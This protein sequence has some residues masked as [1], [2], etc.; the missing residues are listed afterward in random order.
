ML[1]VLQV[2]LAAAAVVVSTLLVWH[3]DLRDAAGFPT[4]P[5]AAFFS[6]AVALAV[7]A[8]G[9]RSTLRPAALWAAAIGVGQ[10]ASLQLVHA[11]PSV[12]YQHYRLASGG[13]E[14]FDAFCWAFL[15]GQALWVA[16]A[17]WPRRAQLRRF[18]ALRLG[19]RGVA[20]VALV[21]V[22]TAAFPSRELGDYA[23]E[24][25]L[26]TAVRVTLLGS[27]VALFVSLPEASRRAL[28]EWTS[29][30]IA[31]P[32]PA[33]RWP[34]L[35]LW[36]AV[37]ATVASAALALFSY[38]R[39]PHVPDEV[40]YLLHAR[41]FAEGALG[42]PVP[43]VP[44]AFDVYLWPCTELRC[45]SPVPPG[46]PAMLSLGWLLG[47]A[48]LV[49]PLLAGAGILATHRLLRRLY[50][51]QT[52]RLTVLLLATSP[53]YLTVSMSWMT[54]AF[55]LVCALVAASCVAR[56]A[57]R[58]NTHWLAA[59]LGG[60]AIGL[61]SLTRPL[62]GVIVAGVL[63]VAALAARLR[64][65]QLALLG[66][67][68]A[69]VGGL[70]FPYNAAITGD[71]LRFP[72]MA[73]ADQALGVGVNSLGFGP[74]KGTH[75][76]GLDP[77]PG[78]GLGDVI[79]NSLLNGVAIDGEL[80]GWAIGSTLPIAIL[81]GLGRLR[82]NDFWLLFW[83]GA[84]VFA[85]AF[86]WYSG[87]PDFAARYWY[88][89]IVPLA[90]LGARGVLE[91]GAGDGEA[92]RR[93]LLVAGALLL[94]LS[95]VVNVVPW[96]AIDKYH[97]YRGMQPGVREILA[98]LDTPEVLLLVAGEQHPDYASALVYTGL[99]PRGDEPIVAWNRSPE[100]AE[101]LRAAFPERRVVFV[102]GPSVTGAGYRVVNPGSGVNG[103]QT[104]RRAGEK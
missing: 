46:W 66:G 88:L 32:S 63:G 84:I 27:V 26:A 48:W 80:F 5:A 96:R 11:G 95:A 38:E 76:G 62:E 15:S 43:P 25:A 44:E 99:D 30:L 91:L 75:W 90:A 3:P 79:V 9:L 12:H 13:F 36:C 100:V 31:G 102:D 97:H 10:A 77:F 1:V 14:P 6:L 74:D 50:D 55:S 4:T 78:H 51:E 59:A 2:A 39:H 65:I 83:V 7:A 98:E 37:F 58:K 85:H 57:A 42:A 103:V 68:T 47:I 24:V 18:V 69:V 40:A 23:R 101:A 19:L 28:S 56:M 35:V 82:R 70:V 34:R 17:L 54:H 16:L 89:S 67:A 73:Y 64:F 41:Y 45:Y 21:F 20:L 81:L 72:I 8:A 94:S 60:V 61:I 104:G 86:Y 53:W 52:A 92:S 49:N 71:A 87:G 93:G 22:G 33:P 29:A